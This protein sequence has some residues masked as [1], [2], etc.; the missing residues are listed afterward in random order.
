MIRHIGFMR[1]HI[2][3]MQGGIVVDIKD[4]ELRCIS[5]MEHSSNTGLRVFEANIRPFIN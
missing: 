5:F 4:F 1:G 2:E 3:F